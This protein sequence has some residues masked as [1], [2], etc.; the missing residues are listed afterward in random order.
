MKPLKKTLVFIVIAWCF[1]AGQTYLAL[2]FLL[3]Y[4]I[5]ND[6]YELIVL[7]ILIDGYYQAFYSVP[8]LSIG[9]T[10]LVGTFNLIKPQLLMYTGKNEVIS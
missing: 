2:P 8:V 3:W 5:K 6:A 10:I 7:A 4:L 9:A 1:V